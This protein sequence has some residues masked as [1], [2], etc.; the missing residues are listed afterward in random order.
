[1]DAKR[2]SQSLTRRE[3]IG[4]TA[5]A[6][7]GLALSGC[8][9]GAEN[10]GALPDPE[11][12]GDR[13]HRRGDDGE[14]FIRPLPG[15]GARCAGQAGARTARRLG[16]HDAGVLRPGSQL[17]KLPLRRSGPQLRGWAPP[18]QRRSDG[19]VPAHTAP[20]DTFPAR[21]LH[22][23]QP[24]VL[25]RMRRALDR[26]ATDTSAAS[27]RRRHRT[28]STC[29]PGRPTGLSN[30]VGHLDVADGLGPHAREP[31]AASPITTSTCRT[32]RS[33]ATSTGTSRGITRCPSLAADIAAGKSGR[34]D[35]RRQRRHDFKEMF[36]AISEDDHP[37]RRHPR[38]SGVPQ[39]GLQRGARRARSGTARFSSSTTTNGAA[40]TTTYRRRSRR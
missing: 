33:G 16:R 12:S 11:N 6:A 14:P 1:M 2:G 5:T 34:S 3:F 8:G 10:P 32:R 23:R 18:D 17:P 22:G 13:S 4:A 31:A 20:G 19:R 37:V 9:A 25:Q 40:S 24:A 36:G 7:G 39:R 27:S 28:A 30:T 35:L 29:T 38:R 26:S 21:L 15:L